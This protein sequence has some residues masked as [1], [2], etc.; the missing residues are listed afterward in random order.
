M[1]KNVA[2][3]RNDAGFADRWIEYCTKN[4]IIFESINCLDNNSIK[5]IR[6]FDVLLW[7]WSHTNM[8]EIIAARSIIK[9]AELM[10]LKVYPN[11]ETCWH[12]NDK[13]AQKYLLESVGAPFVPTYIFYQVEEALA[14][15]NKAQFP[16]VFKLSK[17]AGSANVHLVHDFGEARALT[18][19]A[20]SRGF[21]Q[22]GGGYFDDPA[23]KIR[24]VEQ[25]R[26]YWG[27]L[28]RFPKAFVDSR[29]QLAQWPPEKHYVYFQQFMPGNKFDTRITVIGDRAF[30]FTRDVRK[31]DF[32]AS[33]SGMINYDRAR[34]EPQCIDIAFETARRIGAQSLALDFVSDPSGAPRIVE[35]SYCFNSRAIWH[36]SGYWDVG[37]H[38]H[39]G[40]MWPEDAIL[41]DLLAR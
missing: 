13:I 14:W 22:Q 17:G 41:E 7:H 40:Q 27:V 26:D 21:K 2:I 12:F 35:V 4:K 37:H 1:N 16:L 30:G 5:K 19:K 9:T 15:L 38:W 28:K 10:G 31:N 39:Q 36:C 33:G 34:I 25:R 8:P 29:R 6:E 3:H 18:K 24:S 23:K 11:I 32:R 20:F